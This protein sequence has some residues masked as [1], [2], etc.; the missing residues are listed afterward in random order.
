M[1]L[2]PIFPLIQIQSVTN[3][4]LV[5]YSVFPLDFDSGNFPTTILPFPF[6]IIM[7]KFYY[8]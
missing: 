4:R 3:D 1:L 7:N 8:L 2:S 6:E 5:L